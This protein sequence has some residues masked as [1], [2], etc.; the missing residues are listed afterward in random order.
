[1]KALCGLE[2][3]DCGH[4]IEELVKAGG[5]MLAVLEGLHPQARPSDWVRAI[6]AFKAAAKEAKS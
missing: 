2:N 6:R 3:C 1:M 5:K 4:T